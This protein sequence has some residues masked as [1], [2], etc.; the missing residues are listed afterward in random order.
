MNTIRSVCVYCGSSPGRDEA[1]VKA[2][3]LLGRSL[4]KSGLRLIYGGGTKGIM[5]AVADGA[6][7]AGGKV[8]GIIPRFL[9][10]K[11]ATETALDKLD[12]LVITDNMHERKHR[13][14]EKSDAFV[15]LPGGIGTVEEIVEIMTWAQLGH[16]RKP[17]VFAN[18]KAFWDPM[19]ALIEHMSG[20]GFIHTAHRVKP[21]VVNDPEAIVAAI[22]VA[23]SS[24]D[25]PTEGV[26]AVIDKM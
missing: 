20:E 23:G 14:F 16:H 5:G 7:K 13:M 3:H 19:L 21:L 17:I 10:N 8:T 6:L 2:G 26:Q 9:I 11:E 4:A 22:M 24:V 1:Y 15:A 18:I 12:E 25:A